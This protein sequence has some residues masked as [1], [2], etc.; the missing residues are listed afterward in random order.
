MRLRTAWGVERNVH[1]GRRQVKLKSLPW[2]ISSP[3]ALTTLLG[4]RAIHPAPD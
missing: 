1:Q 3:L 4:G 2:L